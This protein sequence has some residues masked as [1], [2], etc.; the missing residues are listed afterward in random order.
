M[1]GSIESQP[2]RLTPLAGVVVYAP[3]D[4]FSDGTYILARVSSMY[5]E[6]SPMIGRPPT[7]ALVYVVLKS[8]ISSHID[9]SICVFRAAIGTSELESPL[10]EAV[11]VEEVEDDL[12]RLRTIATG[13]MMASKMM[14]I[15]SSIPALALADNSQQLRHDHCSYISFYASSRW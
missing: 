13:M 6:F 2:P 12:R 7:V 15:T 9:G 3:H 1:N 8:V 4:E 5:E 11:P 10:P 14:K